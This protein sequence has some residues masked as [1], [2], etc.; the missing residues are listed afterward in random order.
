M[1]PKVLF[2]SG[3]T[4]CNGDR[5]RK[6]VARERHKL[7]ASSTRQSGKGCLPSACLILLSLSLLLCLTSFDFHEIDAISC[8]PP[9]ATDFDLEIYSLRV[10][11][12]D[13]SQLVRREF[14]RTGCT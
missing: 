11:A 2:Y 14:A 3:V 4:I 5:K 1:S 12:Y 10:I 8:D 9:S 6:Y 7:A 13:V